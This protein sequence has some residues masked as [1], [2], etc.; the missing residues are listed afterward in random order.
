VAA[1]GLGLYTEWKFAPFVDDSRFSY[2]VLH[3]FNLK[4]ITQIMIALGTGLSYYLGK[5]AGFLAPRQGK[6][7]VHKGSAGD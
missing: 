6:S 4:P 2:L 7:S 1:L 5:E 3:C